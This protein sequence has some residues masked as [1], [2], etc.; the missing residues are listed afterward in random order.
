[1][2]VYSIREVGEAIPVIEQAIADATSERSSRLVLRVA[3]DIRL[4]RE[5]GDVLEALLR[6]TPS[7]TAL[8]I[9]SESPAIRFLASTIGLR[10]PNLKVVVT[11]PTQPIEPVQDKPRLVVAH[12]AFVAPT[13]DLGLELERIF[14]RVVMR[15][16][17]HLE[18]SFP[19]D[20]PLPI[21][22]A[23]ELEP[24][25]RRSRLHGLTLVHPSIVT[26]FVVSTLRLRFPRM[27]IDAGDR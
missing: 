11:M 20:E 9:Q 19:S 17:T 14:A 25:L 7:V 5:A 26:G 12:Q 23:N 15:G 18:L 4:G 3:A 6:K 10:L 1:M 24:H 22:I 2:K 8:E 16:S 13:D 21:G 27:R